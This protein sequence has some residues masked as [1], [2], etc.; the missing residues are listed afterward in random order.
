MRPLWFLPED[1][2]GIGSARA[3]RT[4]AYSFIY[5]VGNRLATHGREMYLGPWPTGGSNCGQSPVIPRGDIVRDFL[6]PIAIFTL[7]PAFVPAV[8]GP[9]RPSN[10]VR[11]R[12][13][14]STVPI[15][16]AGFRSSSPSVRGQSGRHSA[17]AAPLPF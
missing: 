15:R 10:F 5:S 2:A 14:S 17:P 9:G 12:G 6:I 1:P 11:F 16:Y 4:N 3:F 8:P 13:R 7:I